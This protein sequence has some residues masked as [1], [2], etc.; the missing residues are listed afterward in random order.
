MLNYNRTFQYLFF[1]LYR[2]LPKMHNQ[3]N[4]V[5]DHRVV[6]ADREANTAHFYT[7]LFYL[8]LNFI[9]KEIFKF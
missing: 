7:N 6:T 5:Q 9:L 1:L 8:E 4:S 3:S 2:I